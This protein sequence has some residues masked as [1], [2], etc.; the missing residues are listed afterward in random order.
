[1]FQTL[2]FLHFRFFFPIFFFLRV[3][4]SHVY[5][6]PSALYRN[7]H[8][9]SAPRCFSFIWAWP[10]GGNV[11]K[12]SGRWLRHTHE[13]LSRDPGSPRK[14]LLSRSRLAHARFEAS[15]HKGFGALFVGVC[16]CGCLAVSIRLTGRLAV[17]RCYRCVS[18]TPRGRVR[19]SR[20]WWWG[21][22]GRSDPPS[23][24]HK[25]DSLLVSSS[26]CR[27]RRQE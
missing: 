23:M 5:S 9:F 8:H 20:W 2:F 10:S 27:N 24:P 12:G 25:G 14:G 17:G 22:R 26:I 3:R 7:T 15:D 13:S 18:T 16:V 19:L 11:S 21:W 6:F 1:M 4:G